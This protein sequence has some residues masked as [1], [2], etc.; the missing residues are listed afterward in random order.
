MTRRR[1]VLVVA[2][3]AALVATTAGTGGVSSGLL[4]RSIEGRLAA[5]E[6]AYLGIDADTV[7]VS[8]NGS[9]GVTLAA[10]TNRFGEDVTVEVTVTGPGGA[11]PAL[12]DVQQLGTLQSGATRPFVADVS[13][14]GQSATGEFVLE[15][16]ARG[17]DVSV[18]A[19]RTLVVE[20]TG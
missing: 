9:D 10:F 7:T 17:E 8:G 14:D 13:C 3:A 12:T 2:L 6:D 11:Y 15:I 4:E 19:T 16:A 5:D 20:C 1:L 18:T